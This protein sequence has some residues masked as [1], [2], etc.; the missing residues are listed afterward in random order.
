MLRIPSLIVSTRAPLHC[1][2]CA[3]PELNAFIQDDWCPSLTQITH[4]IDLFFFHVAHFFPFVHEPTFD[5]SVT[6]DHFVLSM[7]C[8]GYQYGDDPATDGQEGSGYDLS[9]R[10]FHAARKLV[11]QSEDSATDSMRKL[12]IVQAY[13]LH[14]AYV[15][16]Y[17]D[18]EGGSDGLRMHSKMI[19]VS[20]VP[21]CFCPCVC[22]WCV[23]VRP[24]KLSRSSG[25]MQPL[26]TNPTATSDLES[27]WREFIKA[28]SHKR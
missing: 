25:L 3:S 7:C 4:G 8:L 16:M 24:K 6:A 26:P 18:G 22:S 14:Q 12:A 5:P 27:L 19:G 13:L 2:K 1:D 28:E 21:L 17:L 23:C 20:I 10:C 11:A 9:L 15:M